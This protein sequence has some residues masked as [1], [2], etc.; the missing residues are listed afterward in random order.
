VREAR[1]S[2]DISTGEY[3]IPI[4]KLGEYDKTVTP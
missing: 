2:L 4:L 1:Q 3:R